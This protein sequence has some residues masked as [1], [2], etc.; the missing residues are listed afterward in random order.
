MAE[1]KI[2]LWYLRKRIPPIS[3]SALHTC[4][5]NKYFFTLWVDS[6]LEFDYFVSDNHKSTGA[7]YMALFFYLFKSI[8]PWEMLYKTKKKMI[9]DVRWIL[10]IFKNNYWHFT[11]AS[12]KKKHI[13]ANWTYV[14]SSSSTTALA[15]SSP[16]SYGCPMDS[17]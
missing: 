11:I 2:H 13:T 4:M 3:M 8:L 6:K 12:K 17:K 9:A 7:M 14:L 1:V 5:H 15:I 16:I 10:L